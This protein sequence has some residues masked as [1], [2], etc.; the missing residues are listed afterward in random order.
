M[1]EDEDGRLLLARRAFEPW[2][3]RWDIV[4]GFLGEGEHPLD[5]LRREVREETTLEFEPDRY[6]GAWT[7]DYDGRATLNLFWT[8]RFAP[9]EPH[10][11]DDVAEL[12]WFTRDSLPPASELAFHRLVGDVLRVWR[13]EHA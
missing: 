13:D 7:G 4:G 3:G 10:A 12:R 6:F 11:G 8:G 2:L 9:G 1:P 5:G